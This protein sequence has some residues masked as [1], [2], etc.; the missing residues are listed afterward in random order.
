MIRP[1]FFDWQLSSAYGTKKNV[2]EFDTCENR[3]NRVNGDRL[4]TRG[5]SR[6]EPWQRRSAPIPRLP[7]ATSPRGIKIQ[8]SLLRFS[9]EMPQGSRCLEGLQKPHR[10]VHESSLLLFTLQNFFIQLLRGMFPPRRV[11]AISFN[12]VHSFC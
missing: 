11:V 12:C 1:S 4:S 8:P 2:D 3:E 10:H 9:F 7:E 5:R 6:A